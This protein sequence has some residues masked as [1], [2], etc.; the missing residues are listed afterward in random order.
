MYQARYYKSDGSQGSE[1]SLPTALF[2]GVVN[3]PALHQVVK[4]YLSNQ[5]QG[6]AA[7]K[8]RGQVR[9]GSRKPWRQKGTGR[10]RQGGPGR[11]IGDVATR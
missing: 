4:A 9:G 11:S 8:S 10:A 5:R 1:V 2:D 3:E 7:G 6:T